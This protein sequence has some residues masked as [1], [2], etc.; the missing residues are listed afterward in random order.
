M[1]TRALSPRRFSRSAANGEM[2]LF[3]ADSSALVKLVRDEPE[4]AALRATLANAD[5]VS[6]ELVLVEVPGAIRRVVADDRRLPLEVLIDRAGEVIDALALLPL[7]RGLLAAASA[8]AEPALR[9]LDAI[10][11]AAARPTS[12]RWTRSS[13]ITSAKPP[14]LGWQGCAP[15]HRGSGPAPSVACRKAAEPSP[16]ICAVVARRRPG[17]V[18]PARADVGSAGVGSAGVGSAGVGSASCAAWKIRWRNA[19]RG[20]PARPTGDQAVHGGVT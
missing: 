11:I 13:T 5:L 18:R 1:A 16:A 14:R 2:A 3:Y 12:R 15:W 4:S 9:S 6:C 17:A 8:I 7:D 19:R 10:H 20:A